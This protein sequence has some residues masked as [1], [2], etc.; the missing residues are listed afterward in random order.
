M[1]FFGKKKEEGPSSELSLSE[2]QMK[3]AEAGMGEATKAA[4]EAEKADETASA[5]E[6]NA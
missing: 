5:E 1:G 3:E 6:A 2:E 4:I